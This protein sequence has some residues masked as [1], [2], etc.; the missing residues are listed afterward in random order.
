MYVQ[1]ICIATITN[2]TCYQSLF[3][4]MFAHNCLPSPLLLDVSELQ[5]YAEKELLSKDKSLFVLC[6]RIVSSHFTAL[7]LSSCSMS[8]SNLLKTWMKW[9]QVIWVIIPWCECWCIWCHQTVMYCCLMLYVK[10]SCSLCWSQQC[11][12]SWKRHTTCASDESSV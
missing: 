3:T 6:R 2:C 10:P 5:E 1:Y 4:E 8:Q 7:P 11:R 12:Y 9:W